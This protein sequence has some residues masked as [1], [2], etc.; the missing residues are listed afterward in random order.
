MDIFKPVPPCRE[1]VNRKL[2]VNFIFKKYFNSVLK[3]H[4]E[5][6]HTADMQPQKPKSLLK[7]KK[8]KKKLGHL[9]GTAEIIKILTSY[10]M[11]HIVSKARDSKLHSREGRVHLEPG[12]LCPVWGYSARQHWVRVPCC[13]AQLI[14][15]QLLQRPQ[16]VYNHSWWHQASK[17]HFTAA[18]LPAVFLSEDTL[19]LCGSSLS[20]FSTHHGETMVLCT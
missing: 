15:M 20:R 10:L 12:I 19:S 6:P 5:Y 3:Q 13:I 11:G 1:N 18:E 17:Y 2:E 16:G 4:M 8:K 14:Y 9:W 7:E